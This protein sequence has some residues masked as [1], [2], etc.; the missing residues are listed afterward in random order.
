MPYGG[1]N[2]HQAA[3]THGTTNGALQGGMVS[4][5]G[6]V[7][8][9]TSSS[10]TL[11]SPAGGAPRALILPVATTNG[12]STR[13][14]SNSTPPV[15]GPP[16][17][18]RHQSLAAP[19]ETTAMGQAAAARLLVSA[20]T[21]AAITDSASVQ[22]LRAQYHE[23]N[24]YAWSKRQFAAPAPVSHVVMGTAGH[25]EDPLSPEGQLKL[26]RKMRNRRALQ[27]AEALSLKC[28]HVLGM[29]E[30][31]EDPDFFMLDGIDAYL[32]M[33]GPKT[34]TTTTAGG[35]P[36]RKNQHLRLQQK[37]IFETGAA[38]TS[39]L[40]FHPFESILVSSDDHSNLRVWN[41]EEGKKLG[42][43]RNETASNKA[44]RVTSIGWLNEASS[45]LLLTG[46]D[47]GVVR[48]WN[49]VVPTGGGWSPPRL[50]TSFYAHALPGRG[51]GLVTKWVRGA[52]LLL[53]GGSSDR[54]RAW[55]LRREQMVR[56]WDTG[57]EACVTC[58]T[59]TTPIV[60]SLQSGQSSSAGRGGDSGSGNSS[61][62]PP[63]IPSSSLVVAGF[64][65]GKAK[66][67]DVRMDKCVGVLAEHQHWLVMTDF[68][69]GDREL[70][71]GSLTGEMRFWDLRRLKA[72]LR[73]VDVG[74]GPMTAMA[75]H[76]TCPLLAS[77]SYNQFIKVLTLEGDTLT[78]IRYHDG[79]LGQRIGPVATLAFHPCKL[80]LAAGAADSLISI[81]AAHFPHHN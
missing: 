77:G 55:D 58:L 66:I 30:E 29:P 33:R 19:D 46:G 70:L 21:L 4:A 47:D 49:G 51:S 34:P 65:D 16:S 36:N 23:T 39:Q 2:H 25:D 12:S 67:W 57:G 28:A 56:E 80:L 27:E 78:V 31:E 43:F 13:S 74:K 5:N 72:S 6:P 32:S 73:T 81:Y 61:S 1:T 37:A 20:T 15:P 62:G 50:T 52:G 35:S 38:M 69:K 63:A 76:H 11:Q 44:S 42:V 40:V 9:N 45:S 10:S 59:A 3:T 54:L 22:W 18:T 68:V 14:T 53:T 48:V 41:Y 17:L 7:P 64:G 26:Y 24:L 8:T 60:P 71:T 79:I 75:A